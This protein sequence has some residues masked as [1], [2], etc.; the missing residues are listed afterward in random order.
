MDEGILSLMEM[1]QE[2]YYLQELVGRAPSPTS[3]SWHTWGLRTT[4][5]KP[6]PPSPGPGQLW[7]ISNQPVQSSSLD[8]TSQ[9]R[10]RYQGLAQALYPVAVGKPDEP[11]LAAPYKSRNGM[12]YPCFLLRKVGD[13]V[14]RLIFKSS[15]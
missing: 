5:A 13:L 12:V 8:T 3:P 9:S 6:G 1:L 7:A 14:R 15:K 10:A 2:N 4:Q 11:F